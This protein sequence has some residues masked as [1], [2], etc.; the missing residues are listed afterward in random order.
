MKVC[1][2]GA[3]YL[4]QRRKRELYINSIEERIQLQ[5]A[6]DGGPL[7]QLYCTLQDYNNRN[8]WWDWYLKNPSTIWWAVRPTSLQQSMN[9]QYQFSLFLFI[10]H[11]FNSLNFLI[12]LS[13]Y[14]IHLPIRKII[15]TKLHTVKLT[16]S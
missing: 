16:R 5:L 4:Y 7:D 1:A 13:R 15:T 3:L 8:G 12:F 11:L 10:T 14:S 9:K 6:K 2:I